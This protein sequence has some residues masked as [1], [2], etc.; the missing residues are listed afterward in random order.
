MN[1]SRLAYT[2]H[3]S[4]KLASLEHNYTSPQTV[5]FYICRN[6]QQI[7]LKKS[8][9]LHFCYASTAVCWGCAEPLQSQG[10]ISSTQFVLQPTNSCT[11]TTIREA[12]LC[13]E[14]GQT[15]KEG[16]SEVLQLQHQTHMVRTDVDSAGG[17]Q[18]FN[19]EQT[20]V[21]PVVITL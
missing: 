14:T 13:R 5:Y 18:A 17:C 19:T 3:S 16:T 20:T 10:S 21:H 11:N 4:L 15:T 6:K 8:P 9:P 12:N 1:S 2:N 7:C